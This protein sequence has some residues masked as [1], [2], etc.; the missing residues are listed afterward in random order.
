VAY[1]QLLDI[2]AKL[3]LQVSVCTLCTA[4]PFDD[5]AFASLA[6]SALAAFNTVIVD[7]AERRQMP[8]IR[9]EQICTDAG[10]L[11]FTSLVG[12]TKIGGQ[13]IANAVLAAMLETT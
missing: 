6:Q 3:P 9:L 13:K 4:I 2:L 8:I 10:D 11:S 5:P 12:P 7:E 1:A